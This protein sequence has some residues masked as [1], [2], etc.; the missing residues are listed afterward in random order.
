[1]IKRSVLL[2]VAALLCFSVLQAG[3][4][5][6]KKAIKKTIEDYLVGIDHHDVEKVKKTMHAQH[7]HFVTIGDQL[8]AIDRPTYLGLLEQK[9]IGGQ[10]RTHKYESIDVTAGDTASAKVK[11][12]T[13]KGTFVQYL[14]LMKVDENWQ[15]VSIGTKVVP[16]GT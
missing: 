4:K 16:T 10:Q 1:M 13:D 15:I 8:R 9:K 7:I 2:S 12:S 14:T 5:A 6:E 3:E 11:S